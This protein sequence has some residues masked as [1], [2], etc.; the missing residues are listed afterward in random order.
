MKALIVDDNATNRYF[1]EVLLKSRGH[2]TEPAADGIEALQL[3]RADHFDLIVSDILMPRMD[4]YRLCRECKRDERLRDIPF[5]FITSTYTDDKDRHFAA[6]LGAEGF[7]TRPIEPDAL[8]DIIDQ[9]VAKPREGHAT[10]EV[11]DNAAY[12]ADY[13]ERVV[14]KLESKVRDLE[15]EMA[16]RKK[17]EEAL[18]E[19][20]ERLR[21]IAETIEDVFWISSPGVKEM[22]YISPAYE[23]LWERS[24]ESLYK[25]PRSFLDPVHPDDR[26]A[27]ERVLERHAQGQPYDAEYRLVQR[28]GEVRWVQERGFPILDAEGGVRAMT[29]V[30][31]DITE[32]KRLEE[33]LKHEART[34][35][36]TGSSNRRHFFTLAERAI[37]LSRRYQHPLSLLMLDIDHFKAVNDTYGHHAGDLVLQALVQ[38]CR[39]TLRDVDMLGRIGGEEFAVLLPET[40]AEH[41]LQAAERL[42]QAVAAV[43]VPLEDGRAVRFTISLGV[44]NLCDLD[45]DIDALLKRADG[46][47]YRAKEAGRTRVRTAEAT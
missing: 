25:N 26:E 35:P 21:L 32:R 27:L 39:Q 9:V 20:E 28:S 22:L 24:R 17:A 19:R 42:R 23:R 37:R 7:V 10:F 36:L 13:A 15:R 30:V 40:D 29:G 31:S 3:L 18:Q 44:A 38:A 47:L 8:M 33:E 11:K 14:S 16:A 5:L 12:F 34:D 45:E 41:A 4:G 43:E 1:L 2:E 46:A 6:N